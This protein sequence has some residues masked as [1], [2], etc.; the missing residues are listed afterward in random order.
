M[1]RSHVKYL[2]VSVALLYNNRYYHEYHNDNVFHIFVIQIKQPYRVTYK[3]KYKLEN[4][5]PCK[6]MKQVMKEIFNLILT[7]KTLQSSG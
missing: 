3:M 4:S 2:I 1:S 6:N 5:L 7:Y